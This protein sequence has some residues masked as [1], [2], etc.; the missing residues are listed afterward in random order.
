MGCK[1]CGNGSS[2][3]RNK[4]LTF[5]RTRPLKK[6]PIIGSMAAAHGIGEFCKPL[7]GKTRIAYSGHDIVPAIWQRSD[8]LEKLPTW[9][10]SQP[11]GQCSKNCSETNRSLVWSQWRKLYGWTC[12]RYVG[13]VRTLSGTYLRRSF[14]SHSSLFIG[15]LQPR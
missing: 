8:I 11:L 6:A 4:Q 1:I 5:R 7:S 13:N 3:P 14:A 2:Q 9:S 10:P 12:G 15:T